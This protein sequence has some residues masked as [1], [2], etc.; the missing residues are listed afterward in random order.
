MWDPH[1]IPQKE[2]TA[3]VYSGKLPKE[4]LYLGAGAWSQARLK[5]MANAFGSLEL[6][7]AGFPRGLGCPRDVAVGF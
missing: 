2:G 3:E 4:P 7:S 1:T 5:Q 6:S